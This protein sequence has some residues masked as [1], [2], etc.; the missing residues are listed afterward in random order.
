MILIAHPLVGYAQQSTSVQTDNES[1][2]RVRTLVANLGAG[3][4]ARV[5]IFHTPS[6]VF[7]RARLTPDMLERSAYFKL[8]I[9]HIMDSAHQSELLGALRATSVSRQSDAPD[10]RWAIVFYAEDGARFDAIYLNGRG[11]EG[12]IADVPVSVNRKLSEVLE[13]AFGKAFR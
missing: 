11:T 12:Q 13:R 6:R 7:T 1:Q 10:L 4:V 3:K 9:R 8:T 5:E 2:E